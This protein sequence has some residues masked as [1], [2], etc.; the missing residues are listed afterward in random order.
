[1]KVDLI[2][3]LNSQEEQLTFNSR[4][5]RAR[6]FL[7]AFTVPEAKPESLRVAKNSR[8]VWTEIPGNEDLD[9]SQVTKADQGASICLLVEGRLDFYNASATFLP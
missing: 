8:Q 3:S 7:Y 2:I 1:M 5:G 9:F 4:Q 6:E